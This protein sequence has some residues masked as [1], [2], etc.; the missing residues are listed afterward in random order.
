M[1]RLTAALVATALVS[2]PATAAAQSADGLILDSSESSS[3]RPQSSGS[4]LGM[5]VSSLSLLGSSDISLPES[6]RDVDPRYPLPTTGEITEPAIVEK[7]VEDPAIRLERWTVAS[8][9]M[10]RNV[11]VQIMR[12]A[13]PQVPAPMVY[14][15][16]GVDAPYHGGWIGQGEAQKVFRDENVTVVMPTE[17]IAS[18]YSDWVAYDPALGL[19]MWET[20]LTEELAP[21]LE[22]E[23]EL[24]FN[25]RRGIGG[26]SMGTNA[27]VHLAATH[28]EMFHGVFGISGCYSPLSPIG[29]QMAG[30]VVTSRG[31]T[32]ENMWGEFGSDEWIYHDTVSAPEGL[33]HQAV[34]LSAANGAVSAEEAA[35]YRTQ[36]PTNMAVGTMLELGVLRCTQDLDAALRAHGMTHQV[37]EYKEEGAHN[38]INFNRQLQPAWDTIRPALI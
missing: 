37:V 17:A 8:P 9:A 5:A 11:S 25:G 35:A 12:A 31:G 21:L 13:D 18:M 38:W 34:Y 26:L 23:P 30:L 36:D 10:K 7:R 16:D 2:L 27:A 14:L 15:L 32:L 24:N 33:R 19:H 6:M 28:P 4:A 29:R 1:R 20:F 22:A 3:H